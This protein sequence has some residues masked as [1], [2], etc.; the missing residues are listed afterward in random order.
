MHKA[1][2]AT[3]A[4]GALQ[5]ALATDGADAK[6]RDPFAD[7]LAATG[8]QAAKDDAKERMRQ[9]IEASKKNYRPATS[10]YEQRARGAD[11]D[12]VSR[13]NEPSASPSSGVIEDL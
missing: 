4:A 11:A 5:P 13:A 10:L 9:K 7:T 3:V 2:G 8:E 12:N 1:L 6:G